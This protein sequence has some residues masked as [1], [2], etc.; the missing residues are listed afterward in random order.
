MTRGDDPVEIFRCL[1]SM[2]KTYWKMGQPIQALDLYSRSLDILREQ[3]AA[4][5]MDRLLYDIAIINQQLARFD[6][7]LRDLY[8]S[9]VISQRKQNLTQMGQTYQVMGSIY[10]QMGNLDRA[11]GISPKCAGHTRTTGRKDRGCQCP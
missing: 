11:T 3:P 8:A 7:A 6:E 9:L 10:L 4:E 1:R 5:G 2:G